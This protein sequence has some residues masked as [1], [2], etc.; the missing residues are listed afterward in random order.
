MTT[1]QDLENQLAD[2]LRSLGPQLEND[3]FVR[4]LY[5]ALT[6]TRW[7][8]FDRDGAVGVSFKR[9]EELLNKLRDERGRPPLD[10]AQTGGEGEV[11]EWM[12][13]AVLHELGWRAE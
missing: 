2:D 13:D 9:A 11:S 10:L 6:R 1:P 8:R 5:R 12:D 3:R 4:D 7:H